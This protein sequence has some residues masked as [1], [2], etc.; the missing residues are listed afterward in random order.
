MHILGYEATLTL[1][2]KSHNL[3][4]K[5]RAVVRETQGL[6]PII[7]WLR[8]RKTLQL[9]QKVAK[10]TRILNKFDSDLLRDMI[11]YKEVSHIFAVRSEIR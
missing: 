2:K 8:L 10:K 9:Y 1:L 3:E 4:Y 7:K 11:K 5:I 6:Y